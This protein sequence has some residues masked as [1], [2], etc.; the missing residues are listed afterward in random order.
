M[1]ATV[2]EFC[3]AYGLNDKSEQLVDDIYNAL[4]GGDDDRESVRSCD[5]GQENETPISDGD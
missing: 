2:V 4:V 5:K 1:T 3:R